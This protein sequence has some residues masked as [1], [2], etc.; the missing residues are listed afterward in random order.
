MTLFAAM[1]GPGAGSTRARWR[2]AYVPL[3]FA[4]GEAYQF[5]WSHAR[6]RRHSFGGEVEA[7][8]T[9]TIRRL[10]PSC[11]H[12][13]SALALECALAR[14]QVNGLVANVLADFCEP[15]VFL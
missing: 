1:P 8:N 7:L 6:S 4:P 11:R 13:L 2:N 5:D 12:Q 14:S 10:T 9:P 15:S 3:T